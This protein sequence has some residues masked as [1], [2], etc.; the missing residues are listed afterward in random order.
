MKKRASLILAILGL[1]SLIPALVSADIAAKDG[2]PDPFPEA[3]LVHGRFFG[4]L[5]GKTDNSFSRPTL[6]WALCAW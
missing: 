6:R 4:T 1:L 3:T 5:G 2:N